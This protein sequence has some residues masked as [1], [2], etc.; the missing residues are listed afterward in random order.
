MPPTNPTPPRTATW[1]VSNLV[2][3]QIEEVLDT[4][5]ASSRLRAGV[6]LRAFQQ[7]G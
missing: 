1:L 6:A 7:A 4:E 5:L 2:T 3:N